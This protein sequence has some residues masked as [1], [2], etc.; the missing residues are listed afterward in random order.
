VLVELSVRN[1]AVFED[2][3]VP[4]APGMNVVTGETGAGKSVL[5]EGLRLALGEK[6]DP[7]A[8]RGSEAEAEVC[9]SF[10]VAGRDD[11]AEAL[12]EAGLPSEE[13]LVL[14]RVIP[15][16][17]RSR[18]YVNGR[19]VPQSL[20]SSLS[21]LL[22][23]MVGQHGVHHLFSRSAA[24]DLLD[25]FAGCT[26]EA[27]AV[28]ARYRR[29]AALRRDLAE[30][31]S[32]GEAARG[33]LES[34]E[35]QLGEISKAALVPGEEEA[36][37]GELSGLRNAG[38]VAASLSAALEAL[39]GGERSAE[40]AFLFAHQRLR[41]AAALDPRLQ[42]AAEALAS[43]REELADLVREIAS[44]GEE[45]ADTEG[46]RDALEERLSEIRRLRRKYGTDVEGLLA[47]AERLSGERDRL[48]ALLAGEGEIRK[49]LRAEEEGALAAARELSRRRAE[50]A[51]RLS[52]GAER[53]LSLVELPG[54]RIEMALSSRPPEAENLAS[55]GLDEAE[56][57]FSANAG[58]PPAPVA[59]VASGG[60]LSRI[61]LALRNASPPRRGRAPSP[62]RGEGTAGGAG[63]RT[64]VF[65]EVDAGIG[66]KVAER[67]GARL[68][69]LS[70]GSQL[71][72]VTHLPQ[73]AAFADAHLLVVKGAEGGRVVTRVKSLSKNDKID[74]LARM[75]SGAEVTAEARG[76]ARELIE[77]AAKG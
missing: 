45:P 57:L 59:Q 14:R 61:V 44:R 47:L 58:A 77:R 34:V 23:E 27:S 60:E 22:V 16:S 18:A 75:V 54:A 6:S 9:A 19:P 53:E 72:C 46:R 15:A 43:A 5:V 73:V 67:V 7:G 69:A 12:E 64:L 48:A 41:E 4:F 55:H 65:D 52:A 28:R 76:H 56:L 37:A 31:A 51:P 10:D 42:P 1:L 66:G 63:R 11:L 35:F 30:A 68:K 24:L 50:A 17:G 70:A 71:V 39:S 32:R 21:P 13:E 8:V 20:L 3:L 26:A 62:A 33:T 74:E 2:V 25:A 29:V 49:R 40:A 38:K 36:V